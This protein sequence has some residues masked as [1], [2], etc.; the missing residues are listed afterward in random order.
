MGKLTTV[1]K[2]PMLFETQVG[3]HKITMD[4]PPGMGGSNRGPTPPQFFI[5]SLGSCIAA[6]VANYCEN[7]GID[8]TG[9]SVDVTFDKVENPTRLTDL[10]ATVYLPNATCEKRE[11]AIRKVAEHCPV[12]ETIHTMG[13]FEIEILDQVALANKETV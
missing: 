10:K 2:A 3:D 4:V 13:E 9:L 5:A 1:Y 7:H 8:T 6:F 12:H 11:T